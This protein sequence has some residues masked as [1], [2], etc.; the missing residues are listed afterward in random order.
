MRINNKSILMN[1]I[2]SCLQIGFGAID[3]FVFGIAFLGNL[4]DTETKLDAISVFLFIFFIGIGIMILR[5][6]MKRNQ[7]LK[8]LKKYENVIGNVPSIKISELSLIVQQSEYEIEKNIDWMIKKNFFTDAYINYDEK[9]II[10]RSA[11][12]KII[13]QEEQEK[14]EEQKAQAEKKEQAE[15]EEQEEREKR[16]LEYVSVV[17]GCC[18]GTTR[19]V[20]GK[21]GVCDYCRAP[22]SFEE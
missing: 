6:G 14:R 3:L 8:E 16:N 20:K 2:I 13:Q 10:S 1:K 11:Y 17:C 5:F 4:L 7:M 22:I 12:A 15:K 21:T 19:I 9:L 18:Q